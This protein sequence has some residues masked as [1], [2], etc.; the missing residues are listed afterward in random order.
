M[1]KKIIILCLI[2]IFYHES[3]AQCAPEGGLDCSK[4]E[5]IQT[6]SSNVDFVFDDFRKYVTGLTY[7]GSTVL[8]VVADSLVGNSNCQWKLMMYLDNNSGDPGE[9]ESLVAYGSSSSIP[10]LELLQ[11]KVYNS[12]G[13]PI[14]NNIFQQFDISD[15]YV[16]AIIPSGAAE[17]PNCDG[18]PVNTVGSYLT[19]YQEFSFTIDYRITPGFAYRPGAYQL[20]IK[21]CLVE[22]N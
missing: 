14:V 20:N 2:L 6:T 9:W 11:V 15:N 13:T 1:F 18:N 17:F 5:L 7:S 8:R 19:N 10:P 22:V 21:F 12:C 3:K 16:I 4:L